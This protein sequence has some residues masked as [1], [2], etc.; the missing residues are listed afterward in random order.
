MKKLAILL[1]MVMAMM[2]AVPAMAAT[3]EYIPGVKVVTKTIKTANE[4]IKYPQVEMK[5]KDVANRINAQIAQVNKLFI[6]DHAAELADKSVNLMATYKVRYNMNGI[7]SLTLLQEGYVQKAAHGFQAMRGLNFSSVDGS[8]IIPSDVSSL[9]K[10]IKIKDQFAPAYINS[11]LF[12]A[13]KAGKITLMPDFKGITTSP[14]DFY[15]DADT[16]VIA[17][18]QPYEIAP[19]SAGI[20]EVN[21]QDDNK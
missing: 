4:D 3:K 12:A 13:Q 6:E 5:N 11:K 14:V 2:I 16:N 15:F 1:T 10:N 17:I 9:D 8:L 7:L 20:I 18:F 21:L 19:Y